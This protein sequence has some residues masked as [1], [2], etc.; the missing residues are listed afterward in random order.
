MEVK[1]KEKVKKKTLTTW[2]KKTFFSLMKFCFF[3]FAVT[4]K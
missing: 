4:L 1:K 2:T 3:F